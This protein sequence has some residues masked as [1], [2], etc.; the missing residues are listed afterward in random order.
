MPGERIRTDL[1]WRTL[2]QLLRSVV[3]HEM[4]KF[5]RQGA[6]LPHR[7]STASDP[8]EGSA[9]CGVAHGEAMLVGVRVEDNHVVTGGLFDQRDEVTERLNSKPVL[10]PEVA[11][12]LF[13]LLLRC[14]RHYDA[15]MP[16]SAR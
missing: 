5:M 3:E 12:S 6:A 13:R 9:A 11:G 4:R 7:V 15:K 14:R 8:D 10:P 1:F 2:A 16:W